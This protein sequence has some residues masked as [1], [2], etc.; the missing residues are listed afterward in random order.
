M[1][2]FLYPLKTFF[3]SVKI[4]FHRIFAGIIYI[5]HLVLELNLFPASYGHL[6]F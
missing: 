4:H 1:I 5:K 2:Q 3:I 6:R